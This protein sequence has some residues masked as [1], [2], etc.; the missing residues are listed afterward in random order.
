MKKKVIGGLVLS[1][2][3]VYLS[4]RGIHFQGVADGF[5]SIRYGYLLPALAT[6]VF[7]Q[8]VRSVRWGVILSPLVKV[9]QFS[10]F[11]VTNVG[12]LAIIAIPAR[13]GELA[14]PY[15]ITKKSS[16]KMSSALGTIFTERVLDGLTV[17][18]ITVFVLLFTP[19]PPWLVRSSVLFLILTLVLVSAMILMTIKR[20]A[21]LRLLA[22]LVGK[23]PARYAE[24]VNRLLSH[25]IEGF[26]IMVDPKLLVRVTGLSIVIWLADVLAIY[27]L[28]L[29]FGFQ[30]P[31]ASA[32][33]LM[34]ILLIGIAIPTAPGFIGNWHYFCILG[35]SL[36]GVPKTDALTFAI[37]YHFLSIAIIVVL[38]LVFLPFN[39][40][41]IAD[42]RLQAQS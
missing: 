10:L 11:S 29:A 8:I 19:L 32:F 41:S 7:M 9:D 39:R 15:L 38:G 14:R 31:V 5:R 23:L 3:L 42:L 16:I 20:E 6:M 13:L 17:L 34:I 40:F 35:L 33:V 24:R 30:L 28:F 25:F 37:I 2:V 18:V 12:F 1:A 26:R 27:L 22:P 21:S 4:V 36:F